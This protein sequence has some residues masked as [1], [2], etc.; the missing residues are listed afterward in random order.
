MLL[1]IQET[2]CNEKVY[3]TDA[4]FKRNNSFFGCGCV[5]GFGG[6]GYAGD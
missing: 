3:M 5:G 1:V 6:G 2:K 4:S